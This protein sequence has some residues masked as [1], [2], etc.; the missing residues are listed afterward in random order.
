VYLLIF[1]AR[2]LSSYALGRIS[3]QYICDLNAFGTNASGAINEG[4]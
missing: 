2:F 3:E 4:I 1:E